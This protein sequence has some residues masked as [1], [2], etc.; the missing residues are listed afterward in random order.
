DRARE[1]AEKDFG[2]LV[3]GGSGDNFSAGFDVG[4]FVEN[5][6]RADWETIDSAL[7]ELQR[8]VLRLKYSRIPVV[9][10]IYGYTLGA[11]CETMLHCAGVQAAFESYVGLPEANVG[12]IPASGGMAE[13][14]MRAY[15]D[16]PP[17]TILERSDPYPF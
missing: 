6:E 12:L 8:T 13:M 4:F 5:I 10:A 17:G 16:V 7:T 14:V 11:G 15:E 3:I 9:A 2:A 1:R